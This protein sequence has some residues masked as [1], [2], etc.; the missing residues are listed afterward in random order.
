MNV[1]P[2]GLGQVLIYPYYTVR[3]TRSPA[4]RTTRCCRSSTRPA[5]ARRSRFASS[6]ARTAAKCLTST[7]TCRRTTSGPRRS[8]RS[9]DGARHR[10]ARQ[11]LHD[12]RRSRA[13][14]RPDGVRELR[15]HRLN[16]DGAARARPHGKAT[17]KSS[18]WR[19][20]TTASTT[21]HDRHARRRRSPGTAT[22]ATLDRLAS[23]RGD[24]VTRHGRPVR[25]HDADQRRH[26]TDYTRRRGRA[27]QLLAV[28]PAIYEPRRLD[29][30]GPDAGDPAGQPVVNVW[31]G[32]FTSS[33][34]PRHRRSGQR[35][36]DA[37]PRDERVRPRYGTKSGTDWVVT[38]PTKRYYSTS[39]PAT[40]PKLFQRNFNQTVAA[41]DDVS[42]NIYDR[43][44]RTT[45]HAGRVLAAAAHAD[46]TR[47]AGKRTS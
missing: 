27:G 1:N 7:C 35:R 20:S 34:T 33:W 19:R 31:R 17:S 32:N 28:W 21:A 39:A 45:Q 13:P 16:G 44:E 22:C 37:R 30:A 6:K 18:R 36:A 43:E 38:I 41:C 24:A 11:V 29:P 9:G 12:C 42:L 3:A 8:S 40:R 2:D 23:R 15:V 25:R 14:L 46:R 5:S 47:S 4:R 26:G 10:H